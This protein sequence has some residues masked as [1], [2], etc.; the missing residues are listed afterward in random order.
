MI[1][2]PSEVLEVL[3]RTQKALSLVPSLSTRARK[4]TFLPPFPFRS[5]FLSPPLPRSYLF[6]LLLYHPDSPANAEAAQLYR[7]S[8]KEYVRRV[9]QTVEASW[10]EDNEG[11][12]DDEEEEE[13]EAAAEEATGGTQGVQDGGAAAVPTTGSR[14]PPG[15]EV[16]VAGDDGRG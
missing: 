16:E 8:M 14:S 4:L 11:E 12:E 3:R 1:G 7:D 9:K 2:F 13:E 10:M 15:M 5:F 6:T